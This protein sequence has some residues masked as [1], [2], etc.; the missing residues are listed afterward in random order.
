MLKQLLKL[1][2]DYKN[3]KEKAV[4]HTVNVFESKTGSLYFICFS[5]ST[6][7][8]WLIAIFIPAGFEQLYNAYGFS[9]LVIFF[10]ISY[11]SIFLGSKFIFRPTAEELSDDTSIFA[12][13]SA[14]GRKE[15]RSL[16][17]IGFALLHTL[18]FAFYLVSKDL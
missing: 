13:F 4:E 6:I 2:R 3:A 7:L 10:I 9:P 1:N 15:M 17:S 12:A 11:F 14:C 8:A 18:I 16:I 5:A